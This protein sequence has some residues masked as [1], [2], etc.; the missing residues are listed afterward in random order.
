MLTLQ[1]TKEHDSRQ[2]FREVS[3]LQKLESILGKC[4]K[5]CQKLIFSREASLSLN[6]KCEKPGA[7]SGIIPLHRSSLVPRPISIL[8]FKGIGT[9]GTK[10]P[11]CH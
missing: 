8:K 1:R 2:S 3:K 5:A 10:N 11:L 6:K 4:L 7:V 9:T